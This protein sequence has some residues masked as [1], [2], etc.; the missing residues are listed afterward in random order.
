MHLVINPNLFS[1]TS[2]YHV[3]SNGE[4]GHKWQYYLV[5]AKRMLAWSIKPYHGFEMVSCSN[6]CAIYSCPGKCDCC[7]TIPITSPA[8]G[9]CGHIRCRRRMLTS[10]GERSA[11]TM[12]IEWN[13]KYMWP[14]SEADTLIGDYDGLSCRFYEPGEYCALCA[15]NIIYMTHYG[16]KLQSLC[17]AYSCRD[18][19]VRSENMAY[20]RSFNKCDPIAFK[21]A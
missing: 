7:M 10:A 11:K 5:A 2:R 17:C 9:G 8:Q 14:R 12:H 16:V 18:L 4:R 21:L 19:R 20:I 1:S 3:A 13:C 6:V 15:N